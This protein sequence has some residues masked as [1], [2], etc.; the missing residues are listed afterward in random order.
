MFKKLLSYIIPITVFKQKSTISKSL[1]VTWANGK[2]VLDSLNTNY[3]YGN[4]QLVLKKGLQ[5]IGFEN[6]LKME[7]ILVLG[8]A[9]GSVIETLVEKIHFKGQIIGVEIDPA[10]IEIAN[11]YFQLNSYTNLE[12]IIEDAF[13]YVL[14]SN[15]QFDL[16]IIDLFEDTV[17]PSFIFEYLFIDRICQILNSQ[18]SIILN[19][20]ILNEKESIRNAEFIAHFAPSK[21]LVKR[22]KKVQECNELIVIQNRH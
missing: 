2:L 11:S 18:G 14:K 4:L 13:S 20:L 12:I 1:E 8:V 15:S 22:L 7:K 5:C 9:G 3:S 6:I 19:T 17:M 10:V 16:I 21:Y